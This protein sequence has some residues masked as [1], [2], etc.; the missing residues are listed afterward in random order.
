LWE[1]TTLF[2]EYRIS[3]GKASTPTREGTFNIRNKASV[4]KS[5]PWIMPWWMAFAQ[6][7]WG[8]WQGFHELPVD[9]R[10]GLK[11]GIGDIGY[12]VSHGCVRLPVGQAQEVFNWTSVG[13]PVYIHR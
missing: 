9:M 10:T 3:S 7:R 2:K 1:G 13:D 8:A 6:D 12:A 11:E 5:F 4:G